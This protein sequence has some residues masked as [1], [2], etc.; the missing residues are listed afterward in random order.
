MSTQ[1]QSVVESEIGPW[2]QTKWAQVFRVFEAESGGVD[3]V[4]HIDT[5]LIISFMFISFSIFL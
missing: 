1:L 4:R 5:L 2:I 3:P